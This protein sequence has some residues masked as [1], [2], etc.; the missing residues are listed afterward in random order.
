[1]HVEGATPTIDGIS[2]VTPTQEEIAN[3]VAEF[4]NPTQPAVSKK[5]QG[6][7]QKMYDVTVSNASGIVGLADAAVG[8][9]GGAGLQDQDRSRRPR[10]PRHHHGGLRAQEPRRPGEGRSCDILAL[11]LAPHGPC[12]WWGRRHQGLRHL[13]VSTGRSSFPRRSCSPSRRCS[14][15]RTTMRGPGRHWR[16][17]P[18]CAS[19]CRAAGPRASRTTSSAPTSSPIRREDGRLPRS[20]WPRRPSGGY[21]SIQTM[22]WLNPPAIAGAQRHPGHQGDEVPAL[23]R[24]SSPS[25]GG[26]EAQEHALLGPEQSAQ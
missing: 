11:R 16:R 23:L 4:T 20:P 1:M 26:V 21:W 12:S 15:T 3:A 6:V 25:D 19:R 5:S 17:R 9:A 2:Y 13:V 24:G 8:S 10:V 7:S 22:R 18:H 14:P